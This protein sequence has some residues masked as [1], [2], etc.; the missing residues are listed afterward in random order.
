MDIKKL[1]LELISNEFP[2]PLPGSVLSVDGLFCNVQPSNGAAEIKK[3]RLIANT[4]A[5]KYYVL[6]PKVG[7]DV[8]V[9][10]LSKHVGVIALVS[11]VEKVLCKAGDVV[12]ELDANGF[13][14]KH[15]TTV[16]FDIDATGYLVKKDADTLKQILTLI[17]E[18]VQPIVVIYGNNPVYSKLAQALVKINNMLR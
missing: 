4:E 14:L 18:A 1:L 12:Y 10:W 17:V 3:V 9:T 11:E 13:N 2:M 15:G 8:I 7:S 6:V 16:E 5:E